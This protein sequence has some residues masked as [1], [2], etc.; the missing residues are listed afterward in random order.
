MQ[1][2][3]DMSGA[4]LNLEAVRNAVRV[5]DGAAS[6]ECVEADDTLLV[7]GELSTEQLIEALR[8]AGYNVA[9]PEKS[10]CCGGCGCG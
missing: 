10:G 9:A 5:F 1:Y 2:Q 6:V 3:I 7:D 4:A 8:D